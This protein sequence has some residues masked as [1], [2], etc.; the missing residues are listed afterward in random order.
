[1]V[2]GLSASAQNTVS[3]F[4][5]NYSID[6]NNLADASMH[7][8][9]K[10]EKAYMFSESA[11]VS[12]KLTIDHAS[13]TGLMLVASSNGKLKVGVDLTKD[14]LAKAYELDKQNEGAVEFLD[15]TKKV[16]GYKCKHAVISSGN[17]VSDVWYTEKLIPHAVNIDGL[18]QFSEL[19]GFPL[20]FT[21]TTDGSSVTTSASSIVE[22]D[23]ESSIFD[24]Y[25]PEGYRKKTFDEI[26]PSK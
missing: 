14:D 11:M 15:D 25:I 22:N 2:I 6:G 16:L 5:V 7:Y 21:V 1:M 23:V 18:R 12:V 24:L 19:N 4:I 10:G 26:N 13:S 17:S 20:E 8:A 3:D 9:F